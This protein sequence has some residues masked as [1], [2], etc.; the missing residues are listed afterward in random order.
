MTA[1]MTVTSLI[2][3]D[4]SDILLRILCL[5]LK[6]KTESDLRKASSQPEFPLVK[7]SLI[8]LPTPTI[9]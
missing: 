3:F 7:I 6:K 1:A 8:P 4:Q 5:T 9:L 2:E